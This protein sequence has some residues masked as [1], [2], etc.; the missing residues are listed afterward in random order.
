M[1]NKT[2]IKIC[3]VVATILAAGSAHATSITGSTTI[4]GGTF[5]PSNS[6]TLNCGANSSAYAANASHLN[7]NR[8]YFTNNTDPKFYYGTKAGGT[9]YTTVPAA[10]DTASASYT[11]L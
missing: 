7:G 9:A 2:V 10:T 6:V 5:S 4:G 8:L 3:F 11:A 1:S